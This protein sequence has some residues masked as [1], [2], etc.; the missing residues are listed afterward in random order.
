M[1]SKCQLNSDLGYAIPALS[2]F[3]DLLR[4]ASPSVSRS[5]VGGAERFGC[6]EDAI[7]HRRRPSGKSQLAALAKSA[8]A[9]AYSPL[10][11]S[12]L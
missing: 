4:F 12:S 8:L 3:L 10:S 2:L 5:G 1:I 9:G 11:Q 6:A 7:S